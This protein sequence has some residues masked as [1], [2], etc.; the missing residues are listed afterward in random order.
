MRIGFGGFQGDLAMAGYVP[1]YYNYAYDLDEHLAA[2]ADVTVVPLLDGEAVTENHQVYSATFPDAQAMAGFDTLEIDV[3]ATCGPSP[4]DDCGEWDYS[5]YLRLCANEDCSETHEIARYITPYSRPG[6]R[7]WIIEA[8]PFLGLLREGGEQSFKFGMYWNMNPNTM[9]LSFRLS[10][11]GH[12][13]APTEVVP[14]FSSNGDA[15]DDT[16]NERWTPQTF[17]PPA[18]AAKVEL[19]AIVSGHGQDDGN[20][21]AEWCNHQHQFTVND[22]TP[23][24]LDYPG[25]AGQPLGCAEKV[26]EGVVPGQ[27]GNWA[28]G[29]AAWCPG[30]PVQPWVV[31]IT[32]EVELGGSNTLG[33]EGLFDGDAP[34]GGSIRLDAYLVYSK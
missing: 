27:W 28:P 30:L 32:D 9:D 1:R 7:R 18:D 10:D 4:Q 29:R 2:E 3:R 25:E 19:V 22:A 11:R 13:T 16:Y 31:D 26:D 15:F 17:T 33:Y 34:A 14:V 8:T 24:K 21:C 5:A 20:N 6:T 12:D 23:H